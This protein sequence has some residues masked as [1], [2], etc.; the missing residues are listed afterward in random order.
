MS[1]GRSNFCLSP[2]PSPLAPWPLPSS[3]LS[4]ESSLFFFYS[5][6]SSTKRSPMYCRSL[7]PTAR[8]PSASS[9]NMTKDSPLRVEERQQ[10][11]HERQE[12]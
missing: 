5:S 12:H 2:F 7:S 3:P 6:A 8:R 1:F 9:R 4:L 11:R 10:E